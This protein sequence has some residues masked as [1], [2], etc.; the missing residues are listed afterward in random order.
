M[1]KNPG[2]MIW[3]PRKKDPRKKQ[4]NTFQQRV[5][6][7]QAHASTSAMSPILPHIKDKKGI[8]VNMFGRIF[9]T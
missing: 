6:L 1:V 9:N 8:N 2:K 4:D 5:N 3:D 7:S